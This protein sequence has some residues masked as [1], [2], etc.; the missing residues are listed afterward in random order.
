MI[1]AAEW[2]FR[3][4]FKIFK[5][6]CAVILLQSTTFSRG[7][8]RM[9]CKFVPV[10]LV[11]PVFML[12]CE[13]GDGA[14][15]M[16]TA[17]EV[18]QFDTLIG[19]D[20]GVIGDVSAITIGPLG[21]IWMSDRIRHQV[22]AVDPETRAVQV[23]GRE[24]AGPGEMVRP[25]GVAVSDSAVTIFD[26][27]NRRILTFLPDGELVSSRR[28]EVV[29]L[30]PLSLNAR[31]DL[32]VPTLG[33]NRSLVVLNPAD[34]SEPVHLGDALASPPTRISA[35]AIREQVPT[36]F[37][38]NIVP[39]LG[40]EG[41]LWM[42]VQSGA[43]V[44][45]YGPDG[46]LT[47]STELLEPEVALARRDFF[48]A[49]ESDERQGFPLLLTIAAASVT[50]RALWLMLGARNEGRSVLLELDRESGETGRRI[51]M[52]LGS[53]AG[54]FAVDE[55]REYIYATLPEEATLL[56]ARLPR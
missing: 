5:R 33:R 40:E 47:W 44:R 9:W 8:T 43:E 22:L 20:D 30:L 3:D 28:S 15:R 53:P 56:R 27:G 25:E 17:H 31:G 39:V 6:S 55:D 16:G 51:V 12:G 21:R 24:G 10:V 38:N 14:S 35:S 13:H 32:A 11:V 37:L 48:E 42:I 19:T 54:N 18:S 26:S 50:D 29:P 23:V 36:E 2:L 34:G 7:L 46:G 1:N 4:G 45:R 52:S 41:T 49:W